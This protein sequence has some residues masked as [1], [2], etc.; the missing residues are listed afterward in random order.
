MCTSLKKCTHLVVLHPCSIG[1]HGFKGLVVVSFIFWCTHTK[2]STPVI[3]VCHA[4]L[5]DRF[6]KYQKA[7][8]RGGYGG[9]RYEQLEF[10]R[11]VAQSY[12]A[13]SDASWKV[14]D[15][16]LQSFHSFFSMQK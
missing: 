10:Q 12:R 4:K 1:F 14:I 3:Y 7:A 2:S 11:K 8:E 9:E 16:K 5:I 15:I 13:L 6:G